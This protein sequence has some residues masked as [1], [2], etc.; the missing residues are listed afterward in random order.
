MKLPSMKIR[1]L[2]IPAPIIQGGMGIGISNFRLAG[3]VSKEGGLGVLSSAALDRMVSARYGKQIGI[4]DA[5]AIEVEDAKQISGG[6]PVG[7]NLMVAVINQYEDSVLGSLDGGVDVITS[8]AGLP[9]A[10][11]DIINTHPRAND[12]AL[13]PIVS[14]GRAL[15]LICKRWQRAN[16]LPDGVIVEGPLAGGHIGWRKLQ[17]AEAPENALERL[18]EDVLPVA[19]HYN[20]PVI[21][22]GGIYTH[23]DIVNYLEKGCVGVQM[24]TRFLATFE[25]N[26]NERFK[27]M[28]VKSTKDDIE[29]AD[30]PGSPCRMLF[31]VLNKSPFYVQA[32]SKDRQPKCN[33][34]YLLNKGQCLARTENETCFC[35]CNGLL[36]TVGIDKSEAELYTVGANAWRVDKIVSVA[37][38][39]RELKGEPTK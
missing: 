3:T 39:M 37:E 16:R 15:D 23:Q 21:A 14:S 35:I 4:R 13:L 30:I 29:L 17:E 10:L 8:G 9:L 5:A 25:S 34:G 1:H 6:A 26:A 24:G 31:R 28:L 33:K 36:A 27:D 2:T 11:P 7:M 19:R 18:I 32:K 12:V 38:L 20:I 22:A